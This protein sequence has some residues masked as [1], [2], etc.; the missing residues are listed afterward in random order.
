[1]T[2]LNRCCSA[3]AWPIQPP[4][5][6]ARDNTVRQNLLGRAGRLVSAETTDDHSLVRLT[7]RW[8]PDDSGT[9]R[10]LVVENARAKAS[11]RASKPLRSPPA[12]A[13]GRRDPQFAVCRHRRANIPD[14][15]AVQVAEMFSG[16]IDFHRSLRK[17][18]RFSVVY[19]TLEAD[20]EP[21]RSGRVLS[22]EFRNN[23]KTHQAVWFQDPGIQR[24]L[25]HPGR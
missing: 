12:P 6:F 7:A 19:E 16:N 24:R 1:V 22:A 10:R 5:P 8:A 9:F 2:P 3:W 4:R 17:G 18:D 15:V 11:P 14:A 20:G 21:L 25:L 23:G 13:G